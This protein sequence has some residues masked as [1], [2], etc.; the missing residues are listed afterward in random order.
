MR[1]PRSRIRRGRWS[2]QRKSRPPGRRT[3]WPRS[4]PLSRPWR[5]SRSRLYCRPWRRPLGRL[6][7]GVGARRPSG[8]SKPIETDA[9]AKSIAIPL[10]FINPYPRLLAR[11]GIRV[12]IKVPLS[13]T[14]TIPD[15][16][17]RGDTMTTQNRTTT[18]HETAMMTTQIDIH[19]NL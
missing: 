5:R 13:Q 10:D 6:G 17:K 16:T 2:R 9:K 8:G 1:W 3:C 15:N 18:Q 19:L 11:V 14:G 4:R 12:G 7:L